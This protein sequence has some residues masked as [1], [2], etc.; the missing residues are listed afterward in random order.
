M[1]LFSDK[2]EC[3]HDECK[4]FYAM[5]K[6]Y[7]IKI[8]KEKNDDLLLTKRNSP[9]QVSDHSNDN[10][11]GKESAKHK[12]SNTMNGTN[13]ESQAESTREGKNYYYKTIYNYS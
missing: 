6:I 1:C 2:T 4:Q 11:F 12:R 3:E 9:P 7:G 10:L 5:N 13:S 8:N